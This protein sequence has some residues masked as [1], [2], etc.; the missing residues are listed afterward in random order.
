MLSALIFIAILIIGI[1]L[2]ANSR[3]STFSLV[4]SVEMRASPERVFSQLSD[5]KN[6]TNWS[7]WEE[8]DPS[9]TRSHSGAASGKGAKYSW[10]GNKQV[11]EGNMEIT[12][13]VPS[14]NVALDLNFL[15]PFKASNV[16]EFTLKP[17]AAGTYVKWEMRGPLNLF[18]KLFH[19]FMDM[20]GMVG[21]DF[22]KGLRKLKAIVEK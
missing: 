21:K 16:T 22:E 20:D 5:F 15:K 10:L 12:R 14:S 6:W 8:M 4:R 13:A 3:P 1:L 18:M 11:G 17:T 19:L 2:L 7:P 9:M